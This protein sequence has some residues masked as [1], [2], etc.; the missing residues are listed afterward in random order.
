MRAWQLNDGTSPPGLTLE[1]VPQPRPGPGEVLV[2]V[3]AAGVT[4]SELGWYPTTHTTDGGKRSR[5][6]PGHEFSGTIAAAGEG[7][8]DAAAGQEVFGMND[9][10]ADGATAEYCLTRPELIAPKPERATH[11]DAASLPIAAL[12]AWQG[13]FDRAKLAAGERVLIHGG[14][15][16]VGVVAI[17]LARHRGAE[18]ITTASAPQADFLR[19]LG[20]GRVIDYRA[21]AF[22]DGL[23]P[24]DV[25]FDT[26]GGD[27]LA[28]SWNVLRP[29]GRLV[30]IASAGEATSDP[31]IKEAFFIVEPNR[32][33]LVAVARLVD[34]GELHPAV[35]LVVPFARSDAA[36]AQKV[37]RPN[38]HGRVV[39]AVVE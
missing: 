3:H 23:G 27:T 2:R 13:L 30:T 18:V 36:Y 17:Q 35:D 38:G 26:V 15:G 31:R 39:I 34:A 1:D 12:T 22:E 28:R 6:I 7:V 4:P 8:S 29:G 21:A 33:Q 20:A 9:W 10:F 11:A 14:S 19:R 24:I 5:A 25:V 16:A 32:A 37:A